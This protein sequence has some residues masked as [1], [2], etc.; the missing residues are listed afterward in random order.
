M[1]EQGRLLVIRFHSPLIEPDVQISRIRLSDQTR[2]LRPQRDT[3]HRLDQLHQ[4]V[5]LVQLEIRIAADATR[6]T[7]LATQ[8]PAEPSAGVLLHHLPGSRDVTETEVVGPSAHY[9]IQTAHLL[10][11]ITPQR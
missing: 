2:A 11:H 9:L 8:P 6:L 7:V 10:L 5:F 3:S 4:T 1:I